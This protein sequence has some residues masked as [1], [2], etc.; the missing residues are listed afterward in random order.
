MASRWGP[1]WREFEKGPASW[2]IKLSLWNAK[3]HPV[4]TPLTS[5]YGIRKVKKLAKSHVSTIYI[6][7]VSHLK[8]SKSIVPGDLVPLTVN[9]SQY[10]TN[11]LVSPHPFMRERL[12]EL[13][14]WTTVRVELK[15]FYP[16]KP[17]FTLPPKQK[18]V[19]IFRWLWSQMIVA[20]PLPRPMKK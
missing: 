17:A 3:T 12:H 10:T 5:I 19:S 6:S 13:R 8:K 2:F 16:C 7:S 4:N 1:L 20:S 18:W 9:P 14:L 11:C 15:E